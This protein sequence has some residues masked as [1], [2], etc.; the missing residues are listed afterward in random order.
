[1]DAMRVIVDELPPAPWYNTWMPI[2]IAALA[3]GVSLYSLHLSAMHYKNSARPYVWVKAKVYL[4][5]NDL[6]RPDS[7]VMLIFVD[8]APA[9]VKRISLRCYFES[10]KG[11]QDVVYETE[12][13]DIV[14]FPNRDALQ[15]LEWSTGIDKARTKSQNLAN[16]RLAIKI[17]YRA[18]SDDT[19]YSFDGVWRFVPGP[20]RW[21]DEYRKAT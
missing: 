19:V 6:M 18:L 7:S 17:Q 9:Q 4:D 2:L 15:F 1:M 16:L 11:S 21:T 12:E 8:N 10:E 14:W 20:D 5:K 13:T 3:V